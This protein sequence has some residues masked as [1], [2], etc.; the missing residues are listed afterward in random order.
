MTG[1]RNSTSRKREARK[2]GML[3]YVSGLVLKQ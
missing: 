1:R 2:Q 3:R